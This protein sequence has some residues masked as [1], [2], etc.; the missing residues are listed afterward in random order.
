VYPPSLVRSAERENGKVSAIDRGSYPVKVQLAQLTH[1]EPA[2]K[3]VIGS[4]T[5]IE[6]GFVGS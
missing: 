2:K 4:T 3:V 5:I 6:S 1:S